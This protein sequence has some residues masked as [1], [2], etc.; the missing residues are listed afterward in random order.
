MNQDNLV[1]YD[2]LQ[3]RYVE[4]VNHTR[5]R[6]TVHLHLGYLLRCVHGSR[7]KPFPVAV[8]DTG[9]ILSR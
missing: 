7:R 1:C 2:A 4:S 5:S 9:L 8:Q 6:R 3:I